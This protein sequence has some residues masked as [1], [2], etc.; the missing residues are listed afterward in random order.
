MKQFEAIL[1]DLNFQSPKK[2]KTWQRL[3]SLK[4][5][6]LSLKIWD[7]RKI[8]RVK[9]SSSRLIFLPNVY[10]TILKE[11]FI[12]KYPLKGSTYLKYKQDV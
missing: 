4:Q 3:R 10:S 8:N 6:C 7:K 2:Q 9:K 1:L 11:E 5:D 12:L